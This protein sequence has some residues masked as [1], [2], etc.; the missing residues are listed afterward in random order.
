MIQS[1]LRSGAERVVVLY[2]EKFGLCIHYTNCLSTRCNRIEFDQ[3]IPKRSHSSSKCSTRLIHR[4]AGSTRSHHRVA[5]ACFA[6]VPRCFGAADCDS[7]GSA[8]A[9]LENFSGSL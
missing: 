7:G 5:T 6:A 4:L 8:F 1:W 2:W 3:N 9:I